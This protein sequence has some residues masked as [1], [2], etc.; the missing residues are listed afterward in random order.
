MPVE[1]HGNLIDARR[2]FSIFS[3]S[4]DA[5]RKAR[6]DRWSQWSLF[7][8]SLV[9][10]T[11]GRNGSSGTFSIIP[12]SK[13]FQGTDLPYRIAIRSIGWEPPG[14]HVNRFLAN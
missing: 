12:F 14:A 11:P 9:T 13:I 3:G 4:H 2:N 6:R 10:F 8:C 5:L 7:V 1:S